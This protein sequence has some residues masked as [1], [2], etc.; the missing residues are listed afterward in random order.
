VTVSL[1]H[2]KLTQTGTL[3]LL[4]STGAEDEYGNPTDD[5]SDPVTVR[6][7]VSTTRGGTLLTGEDESGLAQTLVE[8]LVVYIEPDAEVTGHARLTVDG[9][10]YEVIGPPFH[11]Y[12]PRTRTP[13]YWEA[14][15]RRTA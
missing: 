7:F 10:T 8:S 12:N 6:C 15:V 1:V 3:V 2:R 9:A 13:E 11:A 4:A 14:T 5:A